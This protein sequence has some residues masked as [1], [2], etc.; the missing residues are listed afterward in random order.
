MY[1]GAN[2]GMSRTIEGVGGSAGAIL[3]IVASEIGFRLKHF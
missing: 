2:G 1:L 3:D